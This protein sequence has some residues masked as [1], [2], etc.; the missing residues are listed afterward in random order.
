MNRTRDFRSARKTREP[1]IARF[2]P[3]EE[4]PEDLRTFD[5]IAAGEAPYG[6]AYEFPG[7]V[8]ADSMLAF[9]EAHGSESGEGALA[10][11]MPLD[12]TLPFLLLVIGEERLAFYRKTLSFTELAQVGGWLWVE[13]VVNIGPSEEDGDEAGPKGSAPPPPT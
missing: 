5:E 8:D 11:E 6:R 10:D 3:D 9:L 13:Y 2:E 12:S 1:L 7:D 4:Y